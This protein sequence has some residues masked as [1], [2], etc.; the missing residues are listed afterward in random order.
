MSVNI[1]FGEYFYNN[2]ILIYK[3]RFSNYTH[4]FPAIHHFFPPRTILFQHLF[5]GIRKKRKREFVF[6]NKS[7][8][9]FF[10]I[11]TDAKDN[12]SI[13]YVQAVVITKIAGLFCTARRIVFWIKIK[14]DM[15]PSIITE[16]MADSSCI[17]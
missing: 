13:F 2:S 9:R 5:I 1:D 11:R 14:N 12:D 4:I 17:L 15:M 8:M 7:G 16:F 10:R 3:I 6:F